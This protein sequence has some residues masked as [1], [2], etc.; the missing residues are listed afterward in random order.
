MQGS[1]TEG[2]PNLDN[3]EGDND[4]ET[5]APE[6]GTI[7]KKAPTKVHFEE[8]KVTKQQPLPPTVGKGPGK[9]IPEKQKPVVESSSDSG[10]SSDSSDDEVTFLKKLVNAN[11][12]TEAALR[13]EL[14]RKE[15]SVSYGHKSLRTLM[16]R[17]CLWTFGKESILSLTRVNHQLWIKRS[18]RRASRLKQWWI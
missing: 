12:F 14:A 2:E 13:E 7:P 6:T 1:L 5:V 18:Q 8:T 11:A 4:D 9:V 15:S 3:P 10:S 17:S 16:K